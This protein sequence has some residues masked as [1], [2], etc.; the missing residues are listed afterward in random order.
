MENRI[1]ALITSFIAMSLVILAYFTRKKSRYLLFQLLCII[2]LI[3]SYFFTVQFFAMIGLFV[4]L[5]RT[6][7]FFI[8]ER[9]NLQAPILASI[10]FSILTIASYITVNLIILKDAKPLDLLCVFALICY[11]FIFRVRN[12]K[13][14]RFTMLVPTILSILFNVLTNAPIFSVLTY[15]IE[16]SA[17]IISIFKY[18]V[19][20]GKKADELS[21]KNN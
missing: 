4:G 10:I 12:L 1:L 17:N 19:I 21:P 8:Y 9:K 14:V 18:H 6:S 13:I 11:A 20:K 7:T 3:V 5:L 2:F 16:L 15:F